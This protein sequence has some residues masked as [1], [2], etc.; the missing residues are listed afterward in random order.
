MAPS[1]V[2]CVLPQR[3]LYHRQ[4]RHVTS[5]NSPAC[6]GIRGT[7]G[8]HRRPYFPEDGKWRVYLP[9]QRK[10]HGQF[11]FTCDSLLFCNLST[12]QWSIQNGGSDLFRLDGNNFYPEKGHIIPD[13][14]EDVDIATSYMRV[15]HQTLTRLP[16]TQAIIF[17][18]RTYLTPLQDIRDEGNGPELADAIDSMPEKLGDYK[19]RP[20]WGKKVC[21]WL[22]E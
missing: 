11:Y 2:D 15:E 1:R 8:Q 21:A 13:E 7:V 22:R 19:M 14:P 20:F 18:V 9:V 5:H 17:C 10:L 12:L 16:K 4:I 3:V 6:T